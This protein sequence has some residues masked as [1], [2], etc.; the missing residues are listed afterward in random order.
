MDNVEK[1]LNSFDILFK[2]ISEKLTK[3]HEQLIILTPFKD[4]EPRVKSLEN[5]KIAT[6]SAKNT[7]AKYNAW[8]VT[9]ILSLGGIIGFA[10]KLI[11]DIWLK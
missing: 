7:S 3:I 2:D 8:I 5:E 1:R 4:L 10:V 6:D 11:L 9:A